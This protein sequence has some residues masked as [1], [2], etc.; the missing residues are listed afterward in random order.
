MYLLRNFEVRQGITVV[1]VIAIIV[2]LVAVA[3]CITVNISTPTVNTSTTM[4]TP[5]VVPAPISTETPAAIN[6]TDQISPLGENR[7]ISL[8]Y[9]KSD[10]NRRFIEAVFGNEALYLNRWNGNFV[11]VGIAGNYTREDVNT[12]N[13]FIARFNNMSSSTRLTNV[14]EE[15]NEELTIR[16]VPSSYFDAMP[17]EKVNK[18]YRARSSLSTRHS[19][20]RMWSVMRYLS[21]PGLPVRKGNT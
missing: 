12:L 2:L 1:S 17:E 9:S 4:A 8:P 3:G 15:E 11:K 18:V 19:T 7:T 16:L 20:T 10:I 21:I 13:T 5:S 14:Y 6:Q